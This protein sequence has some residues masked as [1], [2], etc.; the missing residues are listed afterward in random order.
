MQEAN[1]EKNKQNQIITIFEYS[2]YT[3][4]CWYIYIY[5]CALS[6]VFH[7]ILYFN[8][9]HCIRSA[10]T[11]K[12]KNKKNDIYQK[13][14]ILIRFICFPHNNL[15]WKRTKIKWNILSFGIIIKK[16]VYMYSHMNMSSKIYTYISKTNSIQS[17]LYL[18]HF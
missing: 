11:R 16:N 1:K 3:V 18:S 10:K 13:W 14:A 12:K 8:F 17:N 15:S 9:F 7:R 5:V 2:S 4:Y 6:H